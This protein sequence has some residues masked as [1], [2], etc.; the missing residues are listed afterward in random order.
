MTMCV[1]FEPSKNDAD[2]QLTE[3]NGPIVNLVFDNS[4][5]QL[6]VK[7]CVSKVKVIQSL[8]HHTYGV[9]FFMIRS[10]SDVRFDTSYDVSPVHV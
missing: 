9:V 8:L 7:L 2:H 3:A 6:C 4:K 10:L 1:V 5:R